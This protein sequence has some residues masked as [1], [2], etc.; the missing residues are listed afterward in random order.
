MSLYSPSS[1]TAE[2]PGF[3]HFT[4]CLSL[5]RAFISPQ[6][7]WTA[8]LPDTGA[9]ESTF[10]GYGMPTWPVYDSV[11]WTFSSSGAFAANVSCPDEQFVWHWAQRYFSTAEFWFSWHRLPCLL[12]GG[13]VPS[14]PCVGFSPHPDNSLCLCTVWLTPPVTLLNGFFIQTQDNHFFKESVLK[15]LWCNLVKH[16]R[17]ALLF[18]VWVHDS[19]F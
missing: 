15:R 1:A 18:F 2:I 9:S 3:H 8:A 14:S 12:F 5:Y 13:P 10:G 17:G 7:L 19:P 16:Y 4:R 6:S 11:W